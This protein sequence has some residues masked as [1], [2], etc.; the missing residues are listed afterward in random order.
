MDLKDIVLKHFGFDDESKVRF[1]ERFDNPFIDETIKEYLDESYRF[2]FPLPEELYEKFDK[3]WNLLKKLLPNFIKEYN[4]DY[5]DFFWNQKQYNKNNIKMMKLLKKYFKEINI[6]EYH[7]FI[8]LMNLKLENKFMKLVIYSDETNIPIEDI[9]SSSKA[10]ELFIEAINE[11]RLNKSQ[12][13]EIVL[14][15]NYVDWFLSATEEN[16]RTCL[17]LESPSFSSYW[18]SLAGSI[19]DN[20][21][22]LLY[23]T[24]KKK[25][26]YQGN[27]MDRVLS[28]TWV[29]LDVNSCLNIVKFYPN[30]VISSEDLRKIFPLPIKEI[31]YNYES[32]YSIK[33]LKFVNGYTNYIYQDRTKP[34]SMRGSFKLIGGEKGLKTFRGRDW[35]EGPIFNYKEG[36]KYLIKENLDIM[37]F[38]KE[39]YVCEYCGKLIS[40]ARE[41][42]T[43]DYPDVVYCRECYLKKREREETVYDEDEDEDD[44]IEHE[45]EDDVFSETYNHLR[46]NNYITLSMN[47]FAKFIAG[48]NPFEDTTVG[49]NTIEDAEDFEIKSKA[50]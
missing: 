21:L 26:F 30:E 39:P 25:K 41:I 11:F 34:L 2:R 22:G 36:L 7:K 15:F 35:F 6:A 27:K 1:S 19:I 40:F 16:W 50:N 49:S 38:F 37:E 18:V 24:N 29:L 23:I 43:V 8:K 4:I 33:P 45:D 28:R 46:D 5:K 48:E 20:N 3:G 12:S 31:S 9:E 14:S 13:L 32:K 42:F 17:S 47:D 44:E 10:S